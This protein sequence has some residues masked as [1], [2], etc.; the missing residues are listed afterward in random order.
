VLFAGEALFLGGGD[1][2]TVLEEARGAI[3]VEG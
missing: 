2:V 3:V 1:E